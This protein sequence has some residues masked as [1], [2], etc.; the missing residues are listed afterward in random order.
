MGLDLIWTMHKYTLPKSKAKV[1]VLR[2]VLR[3]I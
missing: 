2:E 3:E 1:T